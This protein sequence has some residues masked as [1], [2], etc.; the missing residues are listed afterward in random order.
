MRREKF[1]PTSNDSEF[2]T[3]PP[4]WVP[5]RIIDV[6]D[7][8]PMRT[9]YNGQEKIKDKFQLVFATKHIGQNGLPL[10]VWQKYTLS[11]HVNSMFRQHL[12]NWKGRDITDEER[13]AFNIE[14]LYGKGCLIN[15][16][17]NTGNEGSI[18][19][20]VGA[21]SQLR[22][23]EEAPPIPSD[24]VRE[25]DRQP[26]KDIG[27]PYFQPGNN[28][29]G[30]AAV[31]PAQPVQ[32]GFQQQPAQS[33]QLINQAVQDKHQHTNNLYGNGQPQTAI[34]QQQV[35]PQQQPAGAG[36]GFDPDADLPFITY[37]KYLDI[38]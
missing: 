10:F 13:A 34:S 33:Q 8:G 37:L 25:L 23:G 5:A 14:N 17:H 15:I 31:A 38:I 29:V 20:N 7:L 21:I 26:S 36:T 35:A 22:P 27:S 4:G 16:I 32:N 6:I 12:K 2:E 19:A 9:F 24:Y 1:I 28:Q 30:Q 18:Y 11:L 3:P